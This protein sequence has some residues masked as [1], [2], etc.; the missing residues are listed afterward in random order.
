MP[1]IHGA[2]IGPGG[3]I[4]AIHVGGGE[5]AEAPVVVSRGVP[6]SSAT[7]QPALMGMWKIGSGREAAVERAVAEHLMAEHG[8]TEP[9][10][11]RDLDHHVAF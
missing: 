4:H 5:V 8:A 6:Y 11:A 1:V 2:T 7:D 9:R 10:H 3:G